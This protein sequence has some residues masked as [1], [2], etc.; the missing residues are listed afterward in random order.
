[1]K[2][3]LLI[4]CL[5]STSVFAL[6]SEELERYSLTGDFLTKTKKEPREL[7]ADNKE[8]P[9]I[10]DRR[11]EK[12]EVVICHQGKEITIKVMDK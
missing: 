9:C 11:Q 6:T 12:I 2:K 5:L 10:R 7:V 3:L 1:M 8:V 4:I